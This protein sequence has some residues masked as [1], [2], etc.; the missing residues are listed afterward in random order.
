M[1]SVLYLHPHPRRPRATPLRVVPQAPAIAPRRNAAQSLLRLGY[2]CCAIAR[3]E[4][5]SVLIDA[6]NYF[7]AFHDAAL[8]AQRS[9]TILAWDFNSQT[10]LHFDPVPKDGP[11]AVLGEFLNYLVRRRRALIGRPAV[12]RLRRERGSARVWAALVR[13]EVEDA[14]HALAALL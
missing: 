4:H 10:R 1:G 5:A 7:R 13:M 9:I 2:N 14:A 6:E 3:A 11:P 12:R 8:K